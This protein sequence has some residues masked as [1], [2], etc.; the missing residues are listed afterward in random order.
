MALTPATNIT[1]EIVAFKSLIAQLVNI[2]I[3]ARSTMYNS[4]DLSCHI[5]TTDIYSFEIDV[6]HDLTVYTD[7]GCNSVTMS[8]A[9]PITNSF[10]IAQFK[11]QQY[12]LA[13]EEIYDRQVE[14]IQQIK[15]ARQR[16]EKDKEAEKLKELAL[17]RSLRQKYGDVE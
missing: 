1:A 3:D 16:A 6:D 2:T 11:N 17:Y 8:F 13:K 14:R 12:A 10:T 9:Y 15:A 5:D 4:I 7:R